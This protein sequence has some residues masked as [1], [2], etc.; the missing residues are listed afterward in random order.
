M[1]A[2]VLGETSG[3]FLYAG[4]NGSGSSQRAGSQQTDAPLYEY[5]NTTKEDMKREIR[6]EDNCAY[7]SRAKAEGKEFQLEDNYA[8]SVGQRRKTE[9]LAPPLSSAE[10]ASQSGKGLKDNCQ[11]CSLD[12]AVG[13]TNPVVVPSE[14]PEEIELKDNYA[15]ETTK[16][17][18]N[19]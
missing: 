7:I 14:H 13:Y 9:D 11:M 18:A 17:S 19:C 12:D 16:K 1:Q 15:Y 3:N 5:V 6:L 8:Y 10:S 4:V 2:I